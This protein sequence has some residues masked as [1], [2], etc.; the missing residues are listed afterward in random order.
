MNQPGEESSGLA[1]G[2]GREPCACDNLHY[3]PPD[4]SGRRS[5]FIPENAWA[6]EPVPPMPRDYGLEQPT[7]GGGMARLAPGN[8]ET[9]M[10]GVSARPYRESDAGMAA[11]GFPRPDP[12]RA[13]RLFAPP[14]PSDF[15]GP[16]RSTNPNVS[17]LPGF[18]PMQRSTFLGESTMAGPG[19]PT[20]AQA[21][22]VQAY[23]QVQQA[24]ADQTKEEEDFAPKD[25]YGPDGKTRWPNLKEEGRTPWTGEGGPLKGKQAEFAAADA[26]TIPGQT[27]AS[28]GERNPAKCAEKYYFYYADKRPHVYCED[29]DEVATNIPTPDGWDSTKTD[30]DLFP[31]D[32]IKDHYLAKFDDAIAKCLEKHKGKDAQLFRSA[33]AAVKRGDAF[34]MLHR[35]N[36]E[37][38][39]AELV[40]AMKCAQKA[41]GTSCN[42]KKVEILYWR[43]NT[44]IA[45]QVGKLYP[46]GFGI[47]KD[48]L[49]DGESVSRLHI[50][51]RICIP[52]RMEWE[53]LYS[54]ECFA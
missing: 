48:V 13:E 15:M 40:E 21:G 25:V 50:K 19:T 10:Q 42:K 33:L 28:F 6:D 44:S 37:F 29:C 52:Y 45:G 35:N 20:L 16:A 27:P 47:P 32:K 4:A 43:A 24:N 51:T 23:A 1:A 7:G 41:D 46:A 17:Y 30:P 2:A 38:Y 3:L 54:V 26:K 12:A 8:L 18:G 31:T 39:I 53:V 9:A 5:I 49:I 36:I 22:I 34:P 14:G 11:N